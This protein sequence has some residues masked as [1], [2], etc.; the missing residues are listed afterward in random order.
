MIT[1]IAEKKK[2]LSMFYRLSIF[3]QI[4]I[5]NKPDCIFPAKNKFK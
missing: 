3:R 1:Y 5:K 2:A 4:Q